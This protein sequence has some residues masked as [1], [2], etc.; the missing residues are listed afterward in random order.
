MIFFLFE[1][2]IC[3]AIIKIKSAAKYDYFCF[4]FKM[5]I[6]FFFIGTSVPFAQGFA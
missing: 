1:Y 6:K 2:Y 5:K 3:N 4:D